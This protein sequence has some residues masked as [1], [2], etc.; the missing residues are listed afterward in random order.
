M[1]SSE[2]FSESVP[3]SFRRPGT[4]DL[5][6]LRHYRDD[7]TTAIACLEDLDDFRRKRAQARRALRRRTKLQSAA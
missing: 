3:A 6:G 2:H 5:E 4:E 7:L 1:L